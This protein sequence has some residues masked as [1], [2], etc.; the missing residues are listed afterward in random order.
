MTQSVDV[1]ALFDRLA[2]L[3]TGGEPD[4]DLTL[5][6]HFTAI[7]D[8]FKI[9]EDQ[10]NPDPDPEDPDPDPDP[11]PDPDPDPDP[12]PN[13]DPDPDPDPNPNP[14]PDPDPN[15]DGGVNPDTGTD[16]FDL[17][18]AII[19]GEST[20]YDTNNSAKKIF[21]SHEE[22]YYKGTNQSSMWISENV[23]SPYVIVDARVPIKVKSV[24]FYHWGAENS[25]Q[26]PDMKRIPRNFSVY[27]GESATGPWLTQ[28]NNSYVVDETSAFHEHKCP[29]DYN[30]VTTWQFWKITIS[31]QEDPKCTLSEARFM[32]DTD[33]SGPTGGEG[34]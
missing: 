16:W 14:D 2:L 7:D 9:I 30:S 19:V 24:I 11:N 6:E 21:D 4:N 15:P 5:E 31:G 10:L 3:V 29:L 12:D 8:R 27:S 34:G 23:D 22:P 25:L 32:R 20:V 1:N 28:G 18:N 13:P 33:L 26:Y 17:R